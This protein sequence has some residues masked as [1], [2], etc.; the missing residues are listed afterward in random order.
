VW[1]IAV[2]PDGKGFM[3]GGADKIVKFW[4]FTVSLNYQ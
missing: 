4:D 2:R 3:S 1:S